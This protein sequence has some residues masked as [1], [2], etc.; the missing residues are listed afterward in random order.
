MKHTCIG[1]RIIAAA[2]LC[3]AA[4]STLAH[5]VEEVGDGRFLVVVGFV[6]EPIFTE[7]RNGLD[8]I[9]RPAGEREAIPGLEGGL[10]A[11]LIA[12]DGETTRAFDIRPQYPHPGRYTFDV[13]LTEPGNYKVRVWGE[14]HD[15]SFDKTFDIDEVKPISTLH[16]PR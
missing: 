16:F 2:F 6:N 7:E 11:E 3:I 15:V 1:T 10:N 4:S 14:I 8:L 12:P 9:I 5:Q 13:V